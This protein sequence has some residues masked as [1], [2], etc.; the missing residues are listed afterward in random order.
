MCKYLNDNLLRLYLPIGIVFGNVNAPLF[1]IPRRVDVRESVRA[2]HVCDAE[3][4]FAILS[5]KFIISI[6]FPPVVIFS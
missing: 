4:R 5:V 2:V 1:A 6:F 3:C